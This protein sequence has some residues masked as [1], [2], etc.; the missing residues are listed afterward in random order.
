MHEDWLD[1]KIYLGVISIA[2]IVDSKFLT[3]VTQWDGLLILEDT[4]GKRHL[5]RF[6][7]IHLE[8]LGMIC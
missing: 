3:D 5:V 8:P 2:V 6:K 1:Q 4:L 7:V